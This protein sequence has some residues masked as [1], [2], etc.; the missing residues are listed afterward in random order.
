VRGIGWIVVGFVLL[1]TTYLANSGCGVVL[2]IEELHAGPDGGT[3]DH[4]GAATTATAGSAGASGMSGTNGGAAGDSATGGS[5]GSSTS[6]GGSGGAPPGDGGPTTVQGTIIDF[7][8]HRVPSIAVRVS[9]SGGVASVTTDA[10]GQFSASNVVPPYDVSFTISTTGGGGNVVHAW[11]FKG[12]RRSNPTLQVYR[13][14]PARSG[15]IDI[16]FSNL[17]LPADSTIG[18][19]VG[20]TDGAF[21]LTTTGPIMYQSGSWSGPATTNASAHALAWKHIPNGW[22]MDTTTGFVAYDSRVV[23]LSEAPPGGSVTFDLAAEAV[24]SG[25]ISGTVVSNGSDR[26]ND[27]YIH[28]TSGAAIQLASLSVTTADFTY[29]VPTL[30]NASISIAGQTGTAG[31]PPFAV[32]HQDGLAAGQTGVRITI[33]VPATLVEPA[34][35]TKPLAANTV[36]RWTG[37]SGVSVWHLTSVNFYEDMFIVTADKQIQIPTPTEGG[38]PLGNGQAYTWSVENHGSIATMDDAT[39]SNGFL[40]SCSRDGEVVGPRRESGSYMESARRL[41]T[42]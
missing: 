20:G 10:T 16:N 39:G 34:D 4:G 13:G 35:N 17:S 12:L 14:V 21:Q 30:P 38:L 42:P 22:P 28:F 27:V 18:V 3:S 5:G 6:S 29:L 2:G 9:S 40:D 25:S 19:A 32:A 26:E 8:R 1:G 33:P 31:R 37:G 7:W 41:V 23:A 24:A 36:F 15:V 11:L